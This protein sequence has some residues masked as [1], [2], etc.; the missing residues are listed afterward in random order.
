MNRSGVAREN[1]DSGRR[2]VCFQEDRHWKRLF[3][4]FCQFGSCIV[5]IAVLVTFVYKILFLRSLFQ[6]C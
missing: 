1:I 4:V 3:V 6:G 5:R 2:G